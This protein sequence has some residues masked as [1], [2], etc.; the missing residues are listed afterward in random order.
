MAPREN[1]RH[2]REGDYSKVGVEG[3]RTGIILKDTGIRDEHGL[4]PLD[5]LFSSPEK[6]PAKRNGVHHNSTIADETDMTIGESTIPE[7]TELLSSRRRSGKTIFPPPRARTPL[8]TALNSSPRRSVGAVSSPARRDSTTPTRATSHLAEKRRLDFS[9]DE[10]RPSIEHSPRKT[11][12][13]LTL[14][15]SSQQTRTLGQKPT[16]S[17]RERGA[18]LSLVEDDEDEDELDN[19]IEG[20]EEEEIPADNTGDIEQDDAPVVKDGFMVDDEPVNFTNGDEDDFPLPTE[21]DTMVG[22]AEPDEVSAI[23][24]QVEEE[25]VKK[26]QRGRPRR[27][28]QHALPESATAADLGDDIAMPP[29]A[30]KRR[31]R[32]PAAS[33]V[34]EDA[35]TD[36]R[37]E[38]VGGADSQS[39]PTKNKSRRGKRR[40]SQLPTTD[41][42]IPEQASQDL[43]KR[44]SKRAKKDVSPAKP[45]GGKAL[46]AQDPN[47]RASSRGGRPR[48]GASVERRRS[49]SR[50]PNIRSTMI[51]RHETPAEDSGART[52]RS[53]RTSIRPLA[54]W[55]GERCEFGDMTVDADK[56]LHLPAIKEIIRTEAV[57]EPRPK[58]SYRSNKRKHRVRT[59]DNESDE[60][61]M[62]PWERVN[63][64]LIS[65]TIVW[66]PTKRRGD[67]EAWEETGE[68]VYDVSPELLS[69]TRPDIAFATRA[70][71]SASREIQGA[72]FRFAKTLTLPFFGAGMVDLPPGGEKRIK[73]SRRMQMVFF[74]YQGRV[75]VTV[76]DTSFG[77]GKGGQW[78][79]PRGN[80]YGISNTSQSKPA[81]IFFAQGCD[82]K[83]ELSGV[84]KGEEGETVLD[85]DAS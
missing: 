54:F 73:N 85:H 22:A 27:S 55:R 63:G 84:G 9:M 17:A 39:L 52:M 24:E 40:S 61:D 12:S 60:D 41:L 10:P 36:T 74:V 66:D 70:I 77:I 67:P 71:E 42:N 5:G 33:K 7:P 65:E 48:K 16:L 56:H 25:V 47:V 11:T 4:E 23:P 28:L 53:G 76:N 50:G 43:D 83:E 37:E 19:L 75:R 3:R 32:P 57:I 81:R 14:V 58:K 45:Q 68:M 26:P 46:S 21:E 82:L 8:H 79:V 35:S 18:D 38:E 1:G 64:V 69:D 34:V 29:P 78:Q 13:S 20:D 44:P 72:S 62:E 51:T 59:V 6:S 31:G 2:K 80:L 15:A 30:V 49:V